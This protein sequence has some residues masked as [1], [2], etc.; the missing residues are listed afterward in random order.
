MPIT[1]SSGRT[2]PGKPRPI[3]DTRRS[4]VQKLIRRLLKSALKPAAI[5]QSVAGTKHGWGMTIQDQLD[6]RALEAWSAGKIAQVDAMVVLSEMIMTT[7]TDIEEFESLYRASEIRLRQVPKLAQ[8]W[9]FVIPFGFRCAKEMKTPVKLRVLGRTF[10]IQSWRSAIRSLG[11]ARVSKALFS[12][13]SHQQR[14]DPEWCITATA[15]GRD[16]DAAWIHL[17]P[18][19][20][21]LRGMIEFVLGYLQQTL[22]WPE[23]PFRTI[24]HP[25]WMFGWNRESK[26]L[27]HREFLTDEPSIEVPS[28]ALLTERLISALRHNLS[29]FSGKPASDADTSSIIADGLRL[30]VQALDSNRHY[31]IYLGLWQCAEAIT[32]VA[33]HGGSGK[34]AGRRLAHFTRDWS[35]DTSA[36]IDVL[37][38]LYEKRNEIV[39]RGVHG[40]LDLEDVNIIKNCCESGLAWL[41]VNAKRLTVRAQLE[42]YYEC[43]ELNDSDFDAV[44]KAVK[45]TRVIRA[46]SGRK[47]K[48]T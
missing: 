36:M 7:A 18:S 31:R 28:E 22:K 29:L 45:F 46:S 39:H 20:D 40:E 13:K 11:E 5:R 4:E 43:S 17:D 41:M 23:G 47:R 1:P 25:P 9:K 14:T 30:Y 42:A 34:K 3:W 2:K 8:K 26:T 16:L 27:E 33:A 32:L 6:F 19:F 37:K 48:R 35:C 21:A 24:P 38:L 44:E 10:A 12:L 15:E